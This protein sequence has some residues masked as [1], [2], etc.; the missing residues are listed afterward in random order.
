MIQYEFNHHLLDP[1]CE[2]GCISIATSG[3]NFFRSEPQ[4]KHIQ[5]LS[6]PYLLKHKWGASGPF[7]QAL[8]SKCIQLVN[9]Y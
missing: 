4:K 9:L 6:L 7:A 2:E 3:F 8:I 5:G 1:D